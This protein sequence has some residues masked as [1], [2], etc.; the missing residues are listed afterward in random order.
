MS[1]L[2]HLLA[3]EVLVVLLRLVN[4]LHENVGGLAMDV[5]VQGSSSSTPFSEH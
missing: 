4:A 5:T 1:V 3:F 2:D